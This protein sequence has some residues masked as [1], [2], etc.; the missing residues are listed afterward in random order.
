MS[1]GTDVALRKGFHKLTA[2]DMA[3]KCRAMLEAR[4]TCEFAALTPGKTYCYKPPY[5]NRFELL[6]IGE[7]T[8]KRTQAVAS[9]DGREPRR[10]YKGS[11]TGIFAE[12]DADLVALAG[13]THEMI[14]KAAIDA[15]LDVPPVVRR[16]Y[17]GLFVEIPERFANGHFSAVERVKQ[18][19]Q[20]APFQRESVSVA[21]VDKF[22]EHAHYLIATA[23]CER[24]RRGALNP[25]M[26]QDYDRM[27]EGHV[28]DIDF[29][30]WLRHLVDVSGIFHVPI[31]AATKIPA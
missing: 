7:V 30:R 25:D 8:P 16:E 15:G 11:Y 17:P 19:L 20:S 14:V 21:D 22:I 4:P 10:I 26:G 3:A 24:T 31:P 12:L 28:N 29:Y 23:R 27:A 6:T 2:Y 5:G 18:A 13:I 1:T 9:V